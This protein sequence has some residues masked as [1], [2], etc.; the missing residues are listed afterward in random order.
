MK[1]FHK[2]LVSCSVLFLLSLIFSCTTEDVSPFTVT[3]N[4]SGANIASDN[5]K[6]SNVALT[7]LSNYSHLLEQ[8]MDSKYITEKELETLSEWRKDPGNWKP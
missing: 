5:F 6:N 2:S 4:I 8:A 1:N 7:T 3:A